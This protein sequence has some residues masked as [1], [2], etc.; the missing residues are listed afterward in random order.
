M[1][2]SNGG[3]VLVKAPNWLGD[4]VASVPALAALRR[5]YEECSFCV[6]GNEA[7]R[8]VLLLSGVR[9][10]FVL[11][12]RHRGRSGGPL[13]AWR[14]AL[15]VLRK[16]SWALGVAFSDS[17]SSALLLRLAG[18]RRIVG[19]AGDGRRVL[20]STALRRKRMGLRPHIIR[21][22]MNLAV[23]AGASQGSERPRLF[24][25]AEVRA[26]AGSILRASGVEP[27]AEVVGICPGAAFGPAKVWPAEKFAAVGRALAGRGM[28]ALVFG[29]RSEVELA[30]RVA[31]GIPGAKQLAGR[32]TVA[33]LAGCLSL[34]RLVLANDSGPAHLA[35][36]VGTPVVVVF[37]ST[38]P[39]WTRPVG[40]HVRVV[41]SGG[42]AC[43]P[44]FGRSC[45]RGYECLRG[46]SEDTVLEAAESLLSDRRPA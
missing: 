30:R 5:A 10:E 39:G 28:S 31:D 9:H 29:T 35:A 20:L 13:G 34:C 3:G 6:V 2:V 4:M 1:S 25:P 36:A 14:G 27:G 44:C 16:K 41:T 8:D 19:Y 18:A 21:E 43:A 24:P 15:S 17:F 45:D 23:A 26:R 38:D 40:E 11:F 12:D 32:T 7:A 42:L 37:G 22:Y 33:E 46:V